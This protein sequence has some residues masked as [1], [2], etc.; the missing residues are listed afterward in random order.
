MT[1]DRQVLVVGRSDGALSG[2]MDELDLLGFRV[3][4]VTSL[5][6]ALDFVNVTHKLSLVIASAEAASDGGEEFL[7]ELKKVRPTLP[8]IWGSK[9]VAEENARRGPRPDSLI[10]EP[11]QPDA[12]QRAVSALLAEHFYPSV[13][14][15]AIK[16]AAL[17]AL[18]TVGDFRVEGGSFLVGNRS[19][20]SDLASIIAFSGDASGH[21]MVSMNSEHARI[22]HRAF[23]P[24]DRPA[25]TDRLEDMVGELCNRIL[26]RINAFFA[27]RGLAVQ[28]T[29]PIFIRA[30]GSTMRYPGRR[31]SFGLELT[32]GDVR[33]PIEYYLADFDEKKA[34]G[35]PT[36]DVVALGEVRYF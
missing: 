4:W 26:G 6:A 34:L 29:T 31:P 30:A 11:F 28:Q 3:V 23:A 15:E 1:A 24:S 21:L 18:G 20:L 25:P 17:E 16:S 27:Q 32:R 19:A 12:V 13:L 14:A 5:R 10:P 7:R 2:V 8:V 9:S 33:V 36:A 35:Q 22:L